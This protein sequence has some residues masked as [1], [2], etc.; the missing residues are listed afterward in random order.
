MFKAILT[1]MFMVISTAL[2]T[3]T[4]ADEQHIVPFDSVDWQPAGLEGAE[5]AI[6]W[7]SEEKANAIWAFRLQP[8]V[9]IPAHTHS[10]DYRGFAIQ[11]NWVHIDE[12][13]NEVTTAQDA[14]AKI[15]ANKPH[16]D[17][18]AGPEVC[19]NILDF[20]GPR[21]IAFPK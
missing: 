11:G 4:Q 14:Y 6:L 19:I 15:E 8:G 21:D 2:T 3:T 10:S 20:D 16:A 17:R 7:G 18:C 9:A 12:H 13:G 5:M 1:A